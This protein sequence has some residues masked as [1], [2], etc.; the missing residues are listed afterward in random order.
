[1]RARRRLTAVTVSK[2]REPGLHHDGGG[3]YLQVSIGAGGVVNRSWILRYML[4]RRPRKMGLGSAEL[5]SL[6]EARERAMQAR[7]L[8]RV[9]AVDP[10]EAR[11][12]ARQAARAEAARNM[13]FEECCNRYIAA[14][15][16]AWTN[17][18]HRNQ[19][20]ETLAAYAYPVMGTLPVGSIDTAIVMRVVEPL[21][22]TKQETAARLRARIERVLDW[23]TV[24]GFRA[25]ENPAR[26]KGHLD[27]LLAKR[28]KARTVRHLAAV[29]HAELPGFM[30]ALKQREG[31]AA[32]ALEFCILTAART[33]EVLHAR[34]DE[35][36]TAAKLWVIPAAR[37]KSAREHRVPLSDSATAILAD[38][39][40]NG[41]FVFEGHRAHMAMLKVLQ[42]MGRRETVHGFRAAFKTW[43]SEQT[44]FPAD[45]VEAALAHVVGDKVERAYARGDLFEKR[46]RLMADWASYLSAPVPKGDVVPLRKA[47]ANA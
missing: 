22:N 6:A 8:A 18:R 16:S 17:A 44:A 33:G 4:D 15:Q 35:I 37:M 27:Q 31:I 23:A 13:T 14:H 10:I 19:W 38:L 26:L 11:L 32:R 34:W 39:P 24:S 43:A 9:E 41:A 21:W 12:A 47:N 40:R 30:G 3:L 1:M 28:N 25:G 7:K 29:P 36:D 45:V 46:R 2:T 5:V 20:P 42:K